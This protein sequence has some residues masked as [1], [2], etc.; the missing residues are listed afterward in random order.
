MQVLKLSDNYSEILSTPECWK[1]R[2][3][4]RGIASFCVFC[5]AKRVT[6][7]GAYG[8]VIIFPFYYGK[9]RNHPLAYSISEKYNKHR[10]TLSK[11]KKI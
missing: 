9:F 2:V 7:H 10:Y 6:G 5:I 4:Q 8:H 11:N 1:Y 3:F